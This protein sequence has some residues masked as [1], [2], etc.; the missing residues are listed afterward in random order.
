MQW[1]ETHADLALDRQRALLADAAARYLTRQAVG[2][3]PYREWLA[4]QLVL[5]ALR[6]AP[7][8]R[9]SLRGLLADEALARPALETAATSRPLHRS[10]LRLRP[11]LRAS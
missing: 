5:L 4:R 10:A 3:A 11:A 7:S 6:L 1:Q 2:A 8:V 9:A